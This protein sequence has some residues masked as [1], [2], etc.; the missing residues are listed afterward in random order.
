MANSIRF[1]EREATVLPKLVAIKSSTQ[2]SIVLEVPVL[3]RSI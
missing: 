1:G 2:L 3:S